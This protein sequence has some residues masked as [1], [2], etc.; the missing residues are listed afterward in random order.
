MIVN[1]FD[2]IQVDLIVE[3]THFD[4]MAKNPSVN[5]SHWD[6][7]GLRNKNES[8]FMRQ[9]LNYLTK[10]TMLAEYTFI[11]VAEYI[12]IYSF[13]SLLNPYFLWKYL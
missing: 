4:R 3:H 13:K 11:Y 12:F 8:P 2:L 9:G 5:Y 1:N 6:D 10:S 7:L